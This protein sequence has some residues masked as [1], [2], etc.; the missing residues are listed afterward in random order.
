[1]A[2]WDIS[3]PEVATPP[4]L[5]ALPGRRGSSSRRR[6]DGLGGRRH[7]G[8]FGDDDAAVL[9]QRL[10]VV[11]VDLVLGGAGQGD[12]ARDVPEPRAFEVVDAG[13]LSAYSLMRPRATFLSSMTTSHISSVDAVLDDDDSPP[14]SDRV[15]T[16]PPSSWNFSTVYWATLPEPETATRLAFEAVAAGLE[17]FLGEVDGSRSRWLRGG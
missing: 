9:H 13:N 15:T 5:A 16:L 6:L 12:V 17:H 14:E 4:A 11:A 3:R 8:A 7:V 1:M 2:F 10:G